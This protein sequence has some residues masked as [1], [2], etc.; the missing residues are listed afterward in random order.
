MK[1][2]CFT[3]LLFGW[4]MIH[5]PATAQQSYELQGQVFNQQDEP[6]SQAHI[7]IE[8]QSKQTVSNEDGHFT[9]QGLSNRQY[10]ITISHIGYQTLHQSVQVGPDSPS[11]EPLRFQLY[12]KWYQAPSVVVTATRS[13]RDIE[14]V[15]EPVTVISDKEIQTSGST[16]LSEILS[17]Q[18]GLTL[19]S[20]HGTGIQVQGFSSEYTKIM[21]DGQ[22]LIG[23]TA[24]TLNLDRI[25]VGNVQQVEMIKGPSSALWGSDALAGVINIITKEGQRPFELGIN[26]RYATNNT[27]DLGLNLST[28]SNNWNQNL[29]LNRNSSGGYRLRPGSISQTVPPYHNYTAS[30]QTSLSLSGG[31]DLTF[32]GRYYRE[33]QSSTDYLGEAENP[34]LLDGDALQEDYSLAPELQLNLGKGWK[35]SLSHYFS[36]YRTDTR[37]HYQQGDSLYEHTQFDQYYNKSELQFN[38]YWNSNHISTIGSGYKHEQLKAQRYD[39]QPAFNSHFIYGQHEW[40]PSKGWDVIAGLRYYN[41]SEYASQL[42]P[43]LSARYKLTDWLHLRGSAGSGFKAPDFRQLFLNF[44][45]PTVGYSVFGSS[46]VRQR[47]QDLQERG[48]ISQILIPLDQLKEIRAERS[49]AYNAGIDLPPTEDLELRINLF[50]NDVNDLIESAPVATRNNGQSIFSYFNLDDVYTRGLETQLRWQP[51]PQFELSAGYQLLDAR[52]KIEDTRTVQD[53][54][55]E[56]IEKKVSSY[57]PMFNRSKHMANLKLYYFWKA[58]DVDANLRGTWHG[59]YGRRDINGNSY[60]DSNEYEDAY[61]IWDAALAKS[62]R[63][64]YTLRLGIDNILDFTRPTDLSY[65]PGRIFYARISLQL[66]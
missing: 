12:Q 3:G 18:T 25:S 51:G 29:Y 48:Q 21:V 4:L 19:S 55:G 11:R 16:R 20:D 34:T 33:Q 46:T 27:W 5:M 66:Y 47:I 22:P 57:K 2:L 52:R 10:F 41:H 49:W 39:G 15:P 59:Q 8:G 7:I 35:S 6:I 9:L 32:K 45:N 31:I 40:M 30:Y 64:R 26:S 37:Y 63:S 14:D 38:K 53:E 54:Q 43:K 17:E 36:R 50:H 23:R 61:M 58:L 42:S 65:I 56:I 28:N 44:T 62:F 60:V 24:G 1:S 13:R